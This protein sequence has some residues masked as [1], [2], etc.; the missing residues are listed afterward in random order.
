MDPEACP[1]PLGPGHGGDCIAAADR[2]D[3]GPLGMV[4]DG[5]GGVPKGHHPIA[6]VLVDGP[7][8]VGHD[9]GDSGEIVAEDLR[10]VGH[11]DLLG[12]AGETVDV[13]EEDREN[14]GAATQDRL[15][16]VGQ[17][18]L[19]ELERNVFSEAPQPRLEAAEDAVDVGDLLEDGVG[20]GTVGEV[21]APQMLGLHGDRMER[22]GDRLGEECGAGEKQGQDSQTDEDTAG[23][24]ALDRAEEIVL[25]HDRAGDPFTPMNGDRADDSQLAGTVDDIG[26]RGCRVGLERLKRCLE[27]GVVGESPEDRRIGIRQPGERHVSTVGTDRRRP[28]GGQR[29]LGG[30]EDEAPDRPAGHPEP[31]QH[32]GQLRERDRHR[33]DAGIGPAFRPDGDGSGDDDRVVGEVG[34]G[35]GEEYSLR[36]SRAG[37]PGAR[38]RV[39]GVVDFGALEDLG[40]RG[41]G[42][43]AADDRA[44][45]GRLG[46]RDET[47]L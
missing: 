42:G 39:V 37:V 33:D 18:F 17:Q 36:V 5:A 38:A 21:E 4:G 13:A 27:L 10:G 34:V 31:R 7:R 23:D 45:G 40:A 9:P 14:F 22:S 1:E 12:E 41:T 25:R 30:I 35:V 44:R 24:V 46:A 20:E 6:D 3:H 8:F 15:G 26:D 19:H 28:G 16:A 11:A 43:A 32:L 29:P 47:T 2:R